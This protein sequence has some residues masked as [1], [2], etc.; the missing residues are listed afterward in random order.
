MTKP[1]LLVVTRNFPPL[2]GGME[3]L[4]KHIVDG[5][6]DEYDVTLIG[7]TGCARFCPPDVRALECPSNAPAFLVCA[8]FK[9]IAVCLRRRFVLVLGGSGLVAPVTALLGMLRGSKKAVHVHGLD[10][11]VRN[12]VYQALFVPFIRRHDLI[13]SNSA[14]TRN[15]AI[16]KGC[17]PD[18]IVVL[19]PGTELPHA[20]QTRIDPDRVAS[21]GLDGKRICLFVG[22]MVRRKGL[23]EF[24]QHAWPE[25]HRNTGNAL[26]LVV[27]DSP[28]NAL[29]RDKDGA[30]AIQAALAD[31][32]EES[33]RF[34]G[35]VDNDFLWQ[36]YALADALIFPLIDVDGDV[37]GFGMVAIEAAACGTPTIAFAVG[38]VVDAVAEGRSGRLVPAGDYP[39]FAQAVV[40]TLEEGAPGAEDCKAHAEKFSWDHHRAALLELLRVARSE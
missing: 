3:R 28:E 1:P 27:G 32:P 5:L 16:G 4:M 2:T 14:N 18:R 29:L 15:L 30:Q 33:V 25:I 35:A 12:G 6:V 31:C 36:C 8:L 20:G 7:P 23:A 26:L 21:L 9:G 19:N 38:G 24:L 10:L 22:R 17:D 11:V 37:E 34:L 39:A 13:V 40:T